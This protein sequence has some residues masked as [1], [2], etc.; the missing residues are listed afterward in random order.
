MGNEKEPCS[1]TRAAWIFGLTGVI[2]V[3]VLAASNFS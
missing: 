2:M 1:H 3:F